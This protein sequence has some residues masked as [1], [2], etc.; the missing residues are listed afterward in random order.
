M[1]NNINFNELWSGQK[2]VQPNPDDLIL[3]VDKLKKANTK[4]IVYTNITLVLTSVF[5]CFIWYYYQPQFITSKI[6]IVL[7]VLAM[8]SFIVASNSSLVLYKKLD[9]G[10]SNQQYLKTLLLIKEKQQ[11]MQTTMLNLY[12]LFLSVGLSLYMYEYVSRMSTLMAVVVCGVTALWFLFNWFYL[13]PKQI[14]KQEAKLN[15]IIAKFEDIQG[16]LN[17]G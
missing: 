16:Q 2:I 3:K 13:R 10:E 7:M 1:D 9:A 12:F 5:I 14:K 6:G 11:F 4:R 17:N 8:L 15:E